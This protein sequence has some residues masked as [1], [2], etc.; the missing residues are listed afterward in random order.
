MRSSKAHTVCHHCNSRVRTESCP[1]A[2]SQEQLRG[3][4]FPCHV[5]SM[6]NVQNEKSFWRTSKNH[7]VLVLLSSLY[8]LLPFEE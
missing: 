3:H 4:L 5:L 2:D 7:F 1:L 8:S 6:K